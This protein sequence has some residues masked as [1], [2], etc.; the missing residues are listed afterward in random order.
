MNKRRISKEMI[1]KIPDK[2]IEEKIEKL[3]IRLKEKEWYTSRELGK[4]INFSYSQI[5]RWMLAKDL[6]YKYLEEDS[7]KVLE[8][9]T[10]YVTR[11]IGPPEELKSWFYK[12]KEI[13]ATMIVRENN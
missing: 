13:I 11:W 7:M 3:Y 10:S 1:E 9:G 6:P 12:N 8:K 2:I 4:I 5:T